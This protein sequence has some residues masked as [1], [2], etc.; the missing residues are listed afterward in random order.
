GSGMFKANLSSQVGT[1]YAPGDHRRDR[2]YSIFYVGTNIGAFLAPLVAG[3]LGEQY[4]WHY[5]FASAGVGMTIAL[6]VYLFVK[7]WLPPDELETAHAK[8]FDKKPLDRDE[9]RSVFA[10]VA[11]LVPT[12]LFWACYEQ[13]GNTISL[14]ADDF[15][16][17]YVDLIVW[18]GEIPTTWFQA[19]N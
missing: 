14:W 4:G 8:G 13:S 9:W 2:A 6:V 12:T 15:T 11:L 1:L 19:F 10:L 5:G 7:R 16:D 18:K 3:T 17:R